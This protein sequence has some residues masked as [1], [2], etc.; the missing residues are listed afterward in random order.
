MDTI[1]KTT[2]FNLCTGCGVCAGVCT[3]KAIAFHKKNGYYQPSINESICNHCGVCLKCCP[4]I[5]SD[6]KKTYNILGVKYP[7]NI[8]VG[9]ILE[10]WLGYAQN[11]LVR[12]NAVSGGVCTAL[13]NHLLKNMGFTCAFLVTTFN[14]GSQVYAKKITKTDNL[15]NTQK[16][17]YIP[18][19][20]EE[21]VHY[22][23]SN[24]EHKVVIVGTSCVIQGMMKVTEVF[25]LNRDN[26][27]FIGLFCDKTMNYNV[28]D[29]FMNYHGNDQKQLSNLYFR[30]KE[31]SKWPGHVKL[32]YTDGT[33]RFLPSS[34]RQKVKDIFCLERCLY[35][36]DKLNQYADISL[37]DDYTN[38]FD[39]DAG[40]NSILIRTEKG[41]SVFNSARYDLVAKEISIDEIVRSQ[42][43]KRRQENLYFSRFKSKRI[44][45][46][47]N[48]IND[49]TAIG[50]LKAKMQRYFKYLI[51]LCKINIGSNYMKEKIVFRIMIALKA[52]R[53]KTQR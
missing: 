16:S 10:F 38:K 21:A 39:Q 18:V 2:G 48:Q 12:N 50:L 15:E 43:I 7:D 9:H 30:T 49:T 31:E 27:F 24:R 45:K 3:K 1:R 51:K 40:S 26:L 22:M 19:S 32:E 46:Q 34:E 20:F 29:Y 44:K 13:V 47:I 23:I 17:R 11:E 42:G 6:Y 37:G 14:Y 36:I 8:F 52:K 28:F 33:Y 5:E 35:C 4:G 25:K 41:K 53:F